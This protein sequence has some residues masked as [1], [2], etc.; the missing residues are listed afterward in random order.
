[1]ECEHLFP[2]AI[3][4]FADGRLFRG[5]RFDVGEAVVMRNRG[6]EERFAGRRYIRAASARLGVNALGALRQTGRVP[7]LLRQN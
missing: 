1:M 7:A 3:F 6:N 2:F 4:D 5:G